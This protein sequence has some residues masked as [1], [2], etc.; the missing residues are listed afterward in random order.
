MK[1]LLES[2]AV[3]IYVFFLSFIIPNIFFLGFFKHYIAG[4]SGIHKIYCEYSKNSKH[5]TELLKLF[6]ESLI[7]A[8]LF[9]MMTEVTKIDNYNLRAGFIGG[10]LHITFEILG[11]HDKFCNFSLKF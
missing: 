7:E 6:V 1:L 5:S 8:I 4:I 10:L 9:V 2:L 11:I 3:F